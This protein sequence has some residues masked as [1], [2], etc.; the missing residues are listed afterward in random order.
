MHADAAQIAVVSDADARPKTIGKTRLKTLRSLDQRTTAARRAGALAKTFE[1]ELGELT[2]AQRVRVETAA[3]LSALAE[4]CTARRLAGDDS[5]SLDDLVRAV[6]AARRAV[7]DL[8]IRPGKVLTPGPTL[9]EYL[10]ANYGTEAGED[11]PDEEQAADDANGETRAS[12]GQRPSE[13][14]A[15]EADEAT[16]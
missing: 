12:D 7:R 5:I 15:A 1:T 4:D 10:K 6:S 14:A 3:M 2:P 8:G 11:A 13:V 9:A 16:E